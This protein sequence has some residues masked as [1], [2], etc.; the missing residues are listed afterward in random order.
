[1][2]RWLLAPWLALLPLLLLA[3][4][5]SDRNSPMRPE[6]AYTD[7]PPA[8]A[9]E[10]MTTNEDL[11]IIDVSVYY[12][13]GYLPGAL[14]YILLGGILEA[15]LTDFDKADSYLVYGHDDGESVEAAELFI[16]AG[17]ARVYRLEGDIGAWIDAGYPLESGF[18]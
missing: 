1:M 13:Y 14:N 10:L 4:C 2:Q 16:D 5:G 8:E 3:G 6:P 15:S 17:F 7:L 11:R 9:F 18:C 12:A